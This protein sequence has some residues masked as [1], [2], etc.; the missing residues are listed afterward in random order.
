MSFSA[1]VKEEICRQKLERKCCALAESFGVLL[2]CHTFSPDTIRIS[3]ANAP[4]MARLPKL[5]KK[6][7]SLNFDVLPPEAAS[8][9][10]S[11]LISDRQKISA[12]YSAFG[13]DA[14]TAVSHHVNYAVLEEECCRIAFLR[15][16]FLAG[17]SVTDP[18][19][20]FHLELATVHHSVARE[21][22]SLMQELGFQPRLSERSGNTLLYF[23]QSDAIADLLTIIGAPVTSMRVLTAKVDKEMRNTVT[24]QINCDSANADKTVSAAQEQLAANRRYSARYGLDTLPEPLKDAALLRITNPA[25][26]LA[27][28]ARL[29]SPPVTKSCLSHRLK[30]IISLADEK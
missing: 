17:G 8:G 18:D 2:F 21:C 12:V 10:R 19:L 15:G 20:R 25:A 13:W 1:D 23:K 22:V 9:R 29:S 5:F 26:S 28:L 3:T 27:D 24:R 14:S 6:A 7:F 30:K 16:A 11:L 4:F